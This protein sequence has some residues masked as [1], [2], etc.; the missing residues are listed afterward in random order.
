MKVVFLKD[1]SSKAK[2]GEIKE[3]ADGYARNF[4]LPRGLALPATSIAIKTA[5]SQV[6]GKARHKARQKEELVELA[7]LV[8]G[9][10]VNFQAKAGEKGKLHG[11]ITSTNIADELSKL[12]N[13]EIDKRKIELDEPLRELGSHNVKINFA[14]DI[15]AQVTVII[16]EEKSK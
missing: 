4:L 13:I 15:M 14:K 3:V 11:S 7:K 8:D 2:A 9:K 5:Q 1:V 12:V 16:E 10:I 6:E